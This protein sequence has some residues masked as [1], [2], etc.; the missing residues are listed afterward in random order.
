MT[1][2]LL[3]LFFVFSSFITFFAQS[4]DLS[5]KLKKNEIYFHS[6]SVSMDIFDKANG[7]TTKG[8]T[9]IEAILN[10]K[11][12]KVTKTGYVIDAGY[13]SMK[14]VISARG[15][16][17]TY[18]SEIP[19][20]EPVSIIFRGLAKSTFQIYLSKYGK[21]EKISGIDNVISTA[22]D[23]LKLISKKDKEAIY[24]EI[25]TSLGEDA[26]RGNFELLFAIY[27]E[28]PIQVNDSWSYVTKV[29]TKNA[30]TDF[31]TKFN[32]LEV[33]DEY[34][35]ISGVG[36]ISPS[37][38]KSNDITSLLYGTSTSEFRLSKTSGWIQNGKVSQT[39]KIHPVNNQK[40]EDKNY[41]FVTTQTSYTGGLLQK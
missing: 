18:G 38:E 13:K 1:S 11:V 34:Y 5:L 6:L 23:D 2:R 15:E 21:I 24:N 27:N 3:F 36:I 4:N 25:A 12:S 20:N 28:K 29:Y 32:L 14:M 10:Y 9:T 26:F 7:K 31:D 39:I 8:N 40:T 22:I 17:I 35:L 16:T 19:D 30:Q 37:K 33:K 41:S